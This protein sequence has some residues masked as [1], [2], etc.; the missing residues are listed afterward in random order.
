MN[1]IDL[2]HLARNNSKIG[3]SLRFSTFAK[4]GNFNF[5]LTVICSIKFDTKL[6]FT[7]DHI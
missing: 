3:S 4:I 7:N 5:E 6:T 2:G 1:L